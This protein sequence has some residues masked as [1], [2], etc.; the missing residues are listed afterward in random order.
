MRYT[1][2]D[3]CK[4]FDVTRD[5]LRHYERV[6]ILAPEVDPTNGYR[7]YD[8]WQINLLWECKRY[9]AMGFS[10]GEIRQIL[11]ADSLERF[12][13]RIERR[14][15]DLEHELAYQRLRLEWAQDYRRLLRGIDDLMGN[16]RVVNVR[17][18]RYVA[19][20]EVHDLLLDEGRSEAG[21][22][23]NAHQAICAPFALFPNKDEGLYFWGFVMWADWYDLLGGPREGSLELPGGRALAT[24]FDAGERGGFGVELFSGLV[25]QAE[26]IGERPA[27]PLYGYLVARTFGEDG[28]YHRYVEGMLPLAQ[29]GEH[30]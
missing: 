30:G 20:R 10:L 17:R 23:V 24:C 18:L 6:G 3:I 27:G 9:Q 1:Q 19:R 21:S 26:A 5:T 11:H 25:K 28:S 13:G 29:G 14:V 2:K 22:F 4:A 8:D 15:E 12:G 16:Y 7:Y